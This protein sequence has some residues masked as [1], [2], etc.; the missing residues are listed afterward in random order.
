[1]RAAG[2]HAAVLRDGPAALVPFPVGGGDWV[3]PGHPGGGPGFLPVDPA[4]GQAGSWRAGDGRG[5]GSARGE[6]G[7]QPGHREAGAGGDLCGRDPGAL[8]ERAA[9]LLR[10]APG[11]RDGATSRPGWNREAGPVP[12]PAVKTETQRK[13][14]AR[15][16]LCHRRASAAAR[17]GLRNAPDRRLLAAARCIGCVDSGTQIIVFGAAGTAMPASRGRR[18]AAVR[19]WRCRIDGHAV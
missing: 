2:Y 18:R 12:V 8:R 16:T 4:G 1:V 10:P 9:C 19:P 3:G 17:H 11:G 6:R 7:G 14:S 15:V 13:P 5:P